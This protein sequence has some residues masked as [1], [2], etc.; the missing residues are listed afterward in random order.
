MWPQ[1]SIIDLTTHTHDTLTCRP[2]GS[3]IRLGD[4]KAQKPAHQTYIIRLISLERFEAG[5]LSH[6]YPC[7]GQENWSQN[8]STEDFSVDKRWTPIL[9]IAQNI[10]HEVKNI[11]F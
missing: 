7:C 5:F 8:W 2:P 9:S 4:S 6:Y 10:L 3:F 1:R 11:L